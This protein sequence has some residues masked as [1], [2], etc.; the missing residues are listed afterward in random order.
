MSKQAKIRG[1]ETVELAKLT[2]RGPKLR[3]LQ[4][5]TVIGR[6]KT[7]NAKIKG[8]NHVLVVYIYH[9]KH[10]LTKFGPKIVKILDVGSGK[11]EERAIKKAKIKGQCFSIVDFIYKD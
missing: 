2:K 1:V 6:E 5:I 3:K 8:Q 10:K 9:L 11:D 7:E 4:S